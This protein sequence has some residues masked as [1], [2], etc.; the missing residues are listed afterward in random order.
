MLKEAKNK[1][2][3]A[4]ISVIP[5]SILVI[6]LFC[7][8]FSSIVPSEAITTNELI[9]FL[10]SLIA[11]IFGMAL[12]SLGSDV[13][14]SK[15]GHY[16]GASV[17]KKQSIIFMAV[18]A[19]LL[20]MMITL[21]EPDLTVLGDLLSKYINAW[22]LK[23]AIGVGVGIFLIIGLMRIIFQKSLKL[24]IMFFYAIVFGFACLF[25][26]KGG[27]SIIS[28]A[29]DSG[30]VTTGPVTVPLLLTFGAGVASVRG[31]KNSSSDSFGIT[32][33]CSIGPLLSSMVLF[34][35]LSQSQDFSQLKN[36]IDINTPLVEVIKVTTIEVL[37]A[38]LP[39][40]VFFIIYQF[41]FI[42][43]YKKELFRICLGFLYT[44]VGLSVFLVAAKFGLIPIGY[45]LGMSLSKPEYA[46][47]YYYLLILL[48]IVIGLAVVLV[49]PGIHILNE[50]V[51]EISGGTIKKRT[52]LIALCIGVATAIVLAVVRELCGSFPIAYYLVP[53]YILSL[54]LTFTVP[55]I[56]T[57]VAFDSGGVAS[58]TMASCFVLPFIIGISESLGSGSGFGVVGLISAVP[59]IA[60]QLVGLISIIK[61]KVAYKAAKKKVREA[62][63][64][65]IIHF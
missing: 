18:I 53:L 43:L 33:L 62:D 39:I 29:F 63:D 17:T 60:I 35:F 51:E 28:I 3:E 8:Q 64:C 36:S 56:Y 22:I 20:G 21:A 26:G 52:M 49:E 6:I 58:G 38:I 1:L 32:G 59:P 45:T 19:F 48:A 23:V 47:Q 57:A 31:G 42:K 12:F 10:V 4:F 34:L 37:L 61:T 13:A 9:T 11:L 30:G 65:Q 2:I 55:D 50:Q 16:I 15:V 41:I 14:M 25:E 7:L 44:F 24:W 5:I 27:D 54:F 40:F 46:G